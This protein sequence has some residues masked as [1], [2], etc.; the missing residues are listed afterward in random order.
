MERAQRLARE[1]VEA[2][3]RQRAAL[4]AEAMKKAEAKA[5]DYKPLILPYKDRDGKIVPCLV[6]G[7]RF[8]H[9]K[10][11]NGEH[12]V[13]PVTREL[14]PEYQLLVWVFSGADQPHQTIYKF[15]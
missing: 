5:K 14:I 2:R 10:T 3:E 6:I 13:D 9:K 4:K 11:E 7:E 15:E 1:A 8:E 12:V